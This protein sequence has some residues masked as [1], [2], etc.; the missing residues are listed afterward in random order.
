M[1]RNKQFKIMTAK[2]HISHSQICAYLSC[3]L[4]Y[5]YRYVERKAPERRGIAL[6]FGIAVHNAVEHYYRSLK[7]TG[8][9][10]PLRHLKELF[11]DALAQSVG[12]ADVP[13]AFNKALPDIDQARSMG[14]RMLEVFTTDH[15]ESNE[16]IVGVELPLSAPLIDEEGLDTGFQ[17]VGII[18]L[19]VADESGNLTVVDLKTAARSRNQKDVDA[20]LQLSG[21]AFLLEANRYIQAEAPVDCRLDV[22]MKTKQPKRVQYSTRRTADDRRRFNMIAVRVLD[23]I[24]AGIFIPNRGWLCNDCEY[25]DA[26]ARWHAA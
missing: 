13:I 11:S 12:A 23:G 24:D 4:K 25:A 5:R 9:P 21:Y 15:N 6:P 3:S 1:G 26:C 17:V 10:A 22:L 16:N 18:D 2:L 8:V 7:E 19:L 14:Y 20:D